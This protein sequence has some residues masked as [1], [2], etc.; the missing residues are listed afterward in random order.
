MTEKDRLNKTLSFK[1]T[2]RVPFMEIALWE[3]TVEE[4]LRQGLPEGGADANLFCGNEY[5]GLEG[6]DL[7]VFNLTFPE[8]CPN[9]KV[10]DED[11]RYIRYIDG[12]GRTRLA[13]KEGTVR[14]MRQS[15]DC[16]VD[17][18]VKSGKDFQ[19]LK[20]LYISNPEDRLPKDWEQTLEVLDTSTRPSTF[21]D[22]YFGSFGFYSML[23]N[24]I[25][26]ENLSYMFYD[27]PNL[28]RECLEFLTDFITGGWLAETLEKAQFDLYYIHEDMA[29]K[30]GPLISPDMFR[31]FF[32]PSYKTFVNFLKRHGVKNIVVDTDGN[33]APLIPEFLDAG[34]E[35]F[36]PIERAAGL[37]PL[38]LRKQYGNSF[39][40][41][42]GVDKRVL[43]NGRK[44]IDSE[45]YHVLP[46]MLEKGGFIP[47][48]DHSVPPDVTLENFEY[49]LQVKR[50][51]I[52]GG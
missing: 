22:R 1:G 32:L 40:M 38:S 44:E 7:V 43:K 27:D 50:K 6:Y 13:L 46:P 31:D 23:R 25:G 5:F 45:L 8:P 42:G 30:S 24:W 4:W 17:F 14:G 21:L 35:G 19:A 29:G 28:V 39:F 16:Y 20:K 10:I 49:Y 33:F 51:I 12:M 41:I 47:T 48:V 2:D 9:E 15:M 34:V 36:G 11:D 37:D 18:P 52:E 3:Q 26:T